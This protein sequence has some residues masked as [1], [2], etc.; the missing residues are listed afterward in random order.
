MIRQKNG[1]ENDHLSEYCCDLGFRL[2]GVRFSTNAGLTPSP[3]ESFTENGGRP[4]GRH[5]FMGSSEHFHNSDSLWVIS[6]KDES[7]PA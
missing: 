4:S 3:K 6:F 7:V 2:L 1:D 5:F